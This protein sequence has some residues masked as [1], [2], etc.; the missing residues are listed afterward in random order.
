MQ[1]STCYDLY[2]SVHHVGALGGGHYIAAVRDDNGQIQRA[3][4]T[5]SPLSDVAPSPPPSPASPSTLSQKWWCYNDSVV[6]P[7]TAAKDIVSPSAYVLFYVRRDVRNAHVREVH[8]ASPPPI[9]YGSDAMSESEGSAAEGEHLH[10]RHGDGKMEME[11]SPV[12]TESEE[13]DR[14][15]KQQMGDQCILS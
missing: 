2:S 14:F 5:T 15:G 4:T 1:E 7:V 9:R 6:M 10:H 13:S 12:S 11:G 8:T 3:V